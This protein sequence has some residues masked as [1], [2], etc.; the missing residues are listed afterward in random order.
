MKPFFQTI[1]FNP[2]PAIK[3]HCRGLVCIERSIPLEL[4]LAEIE[5]EG[6]ELCGIPFATYASST[7][8]ANSAPK[9]G[10]LP[11]VIDPRCHY[12]P[13]HEETHCLWPHTLFTLKLGLNIFG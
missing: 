5:Q 2:I 12:R 9:S 4:Q 7:I 1:G 11:S 13:S 6:Q 3:M 10:R 8:P